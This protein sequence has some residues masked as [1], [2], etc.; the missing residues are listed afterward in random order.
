MDE[1]VRFSSVSEIVSGNTSIV[2]SRICN[3]VF[4]HE[5]PSSICIITLSIP[6]KSILTINSSIEIR[7]DTSWNSF[8]ENFNN[9]TAVMKKRIFFRT[10]TYCYHCSQ[11]NP[12]IYYRPCGHGA[13]HYKCLVTL[14]DLRTQHMLPLCPHC[15]ISFPIDPGLS[16]SSPALTR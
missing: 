10:M 7:T 11:P 1:V 14:I 2:S 8:I 5:N 9:T 16:A 4:D 3:L 15:H 12:D 13:Y 6:Q